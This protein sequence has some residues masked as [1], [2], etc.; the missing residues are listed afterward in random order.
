[1][2]HSDLCSL[3]GKHDRLAVSVIWTV[4]ADFE[5]I[6]S[7]WYGRTVIH[8]V[9]AMTYEQAHNIL[10]DKE[11]DEEGKEPP[12]PLT[13]G[14]HVDKSRI[15]YLKS[16]LLILTK[17]S[18]KLRHNRE[19]IGG[20]LDLSSGDR[21]SELKFTLDSDGN[22][23][24]VLP[25]KELEIHHTIAEMMIMANSFVAKTIF[26]RFPNIALLRIHRSVDV[27]G[28]NFE[29]LESLLKAGGVQFDGKNNRALAQSLKRA[30]MNA[31]GSPVFS[32][33]QSVATRAMN[34]AQYVC[35]GLHEGKI[36]LGHY[37]LGID[38][39]THFT[40]P[41]R[42]YADIIVH[43]LLLAS[44]SKRKPF[45]ITF[46]RNDINLG[47]GKKNSMPDSQ[48]ISL[49]VGNGL[50]KE[51]VEIYNRL[52]A[53]EMLDVPID[54]ESELATGIRIDGSKVNKKEESQLVKDPYTPTR[55]AKI[56]IR[57][58]EQNRKA[59]S[60]SMQCQR[61]FLSLY[62]RNKIEFARAVV[63]KLRENGLI[64]YVPKFDVKGPVFL[65][66]HSNVQIDPQLL[67]VSP[68]SGLPPSMSN[69]KG[70]NGQCLLNETNTKLELRIPGCQESII[71]KCLDVIRVQ[72]SCDISDS[73]SRVPPPRLHLISL[74]QK[75][76]S[77][78]HREHE[79]TIINSINVKSVEESNRP[80]QF[81]KIT[82]ACNSKK[83]SI[84]GVIESVSINLNLDEIPLRLVK[85][86]KKYN[87]NNRVKAVPGRLAYGG[88]KNITNHSASSDLGQNCTALDI[89]TSVCMDDSRR[90]EREATARIQRLAAGKRNNKRAK[91][92]KK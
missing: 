39:Y 43:R 7:I 52:D 74:Q 5:K 34:E 62:F 14:G 30:K 50:R 92:L 44:L 76:P 2:Y 16:G 40:S 29:E 28:G 47:G 73:I 8:N 69:V 33:F 36:G 89:H 78:S 84:F 31:E 67:R 4:S 26:E 60:C 37:G 32:L 75:S 85:S 23:T 49:L 91:A 90:I 13:A 20:A 48:A 53:H 83:P 58:N 63:V 71:L 10:H 6:K 56:C 79:K 27:Q 35:T 46:R 19:V 25:K 65:S 66:D 11:P 42:R 38:L 70:Y 9:Q 80:Y 81:K 82:S 15:K 57:L 72:L 77:K 59:K 1:M 12:P 41:I 68:S 51:E 61:L 54:G 86:H 3:H 22:P 87:S 18:R 17:M 45:E 88:F 24:R 21:G 55:L 64:V